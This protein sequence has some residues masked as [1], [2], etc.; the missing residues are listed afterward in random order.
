MK[1][2]SIIFFIIL[3]IIILFFFTMLYGIGYDKLITS[4]LS[5]GRFFGMG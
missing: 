4:L 3:I 2:H 5:W 1:G